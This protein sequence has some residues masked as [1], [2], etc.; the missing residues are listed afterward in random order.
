MLISAILYPASSVLGHPESAELLFYIL[1]NLIFVPFYATRYDRRFLVTWHLISLTFCFV[2]FFTIESLVGIQSLGVGLLSSL[3]TIFW[4][5]AISVL[6][7]LFSSLASRDPQ[8]LKRQQLY[9]RIPHQQLA[10]LLSARYGSTLLLPYSVAFLLTAG[11]GSIRPYAYLVLV[12]A[13]VTAC[14]LFMR[15]GRHLKELRL[16]AQAQTSLQ[17]PVDS[18]YKYLAI[19]VSMIVISAFLILLINR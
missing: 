6:T 2:S 10:L 16:E 7:F 15:S 13:A 11:L 14:F 9:L 4:L 19:P 18:D 12:I 3:G 17:Q 1:L 5:G 8:V